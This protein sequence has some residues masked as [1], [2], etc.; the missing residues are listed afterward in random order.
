MSGLQ[1]GYTLLTSVVLG[2]CALGAHVRPQAREVLAAALFIVFLTYAMKTAIALASL[3]DPELKP[4]ASMVFYPLQDAI[5]V[6]M[7]VWAYMRQRATWKLCLLGCFIAQIVGHAVFWGSRDG[8]I[9][10]LYTYTVWNNL[11]YLLTMLAL[12][13]AGGKHV[14][15]WVADLWHRHH[16]GGVCDPVPGGS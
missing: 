4:P 11:G 12:A 5:S 6:V 3:F 1:V 2:I 14:G 15:S 13:L 8:S 16:G 9:F 10:A 7:C